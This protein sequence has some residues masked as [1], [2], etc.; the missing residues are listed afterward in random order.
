MREFKPEVNIKAE[1]V[2]S[3]LTQKQIAEKLE[4]STTSYCYKESGRRQFTVEE[5]INICKILKVEPQGLLG[6]L[7]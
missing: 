6:K 1:R 7:L 3:K 5:F 4:M 2:R